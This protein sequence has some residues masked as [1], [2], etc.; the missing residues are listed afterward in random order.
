MAL[1]GTKKILNSRTQLIA[2]IVVSVIVVM[3]VAFFGYSKYMTTQVNKWNDK[4]YPNVYVQ[5]VN[6]S[7]MTKEEATNEL[8]EK[9]K[10]A[11]VNKKITVKVKDKDY[12]M[13]YSKLNAEYNIEDTVDKAFDFGKNKKLGE[14]YKLIKSK[15]KEDLE[16]EFTH[17]PEY[18]KEFVNSIANEVNKKP[19]DAKLDVSSGFAI[20]DEVAGYKLD[21]ENLEKGILDS[22]NGK[23]DENIVVDAVVNE[24]KPKVTAEA[25][26]KVNGKISSYSTSYGT[27]SE[28]RAF[29]VELATKAID[30]TILMPGEVFSYNG[31]VGERSAERGYKNAGVIIGNKVENGIG[32][33][34]CQVSSTL[35]QAI[36]RSGLNSVE[37]INHSLPVGYMTKGFDATVAWDSLDYKFKNTFDFPIYIEGVTYGRNVSFNIYGDASASNKT[38]EIYSEIVE[39]LQPTTSTVDDSSIPEGQTVVEQNP[40][41]GYRVKTYRKVY[42]GGNLVDTQLIS[43]DTYQ[44][45]NGITKKGTKKAE[46][47]TPT[48]EPAPAPAPTPEPTPTPEPVPEPSVPQGNGEQGK[49]AQ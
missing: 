31:V 42:E 2:I 34:I 47:P 13:D 48:P 38:Y 32:G 24:D 33:G 35:Y 36:L 37:R 30:G 23:I 43:T 5:G 14:Q 25:L 21:S 1:N 44:A 41:T 11:I 39:T 18:V 29:N 17:N 45:V 26:K 6:L 40:S 19:Q 15:N 7:G 28:G 4:V 27:S 10:D 12:S 46:V 16:L 8:N 22:I 20:T 9:F 3:G 49:P